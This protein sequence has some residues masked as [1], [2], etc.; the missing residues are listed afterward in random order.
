MVLPK[1]EEL[2]GENDA[3]ILILAVTTYD[4]WKQAMKR[5]GLERL[6]ADSKDTKTIDA[7]FQKLPP[8]KDSAYN[9]LEIQARVKALQE[10]SKLTIGWLED[11]IS[12]HTP[13][14]LNINPRFKVMLALNT[15]L[16]PQLAN[17][18]EIQS[19]LQSLYTSIPKEDLFFNLHRMFAPPGEKR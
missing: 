17:A 12:S 19:Q 9:L 8:P 16:H 13:Q 11:K 4:G 14:D 1:L 7:S 5:E 3:N 10:L 18:L 6:K 15:S 2:I